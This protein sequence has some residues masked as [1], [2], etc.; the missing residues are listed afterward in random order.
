MTQP[1]EPGVWIFDGEGGRFPAAVFTTVE[2]AEEWIARHRL[3]GVLTWYPL[4]VPVYEW[5]IAKGYWKPSKDYQAEPRFIQQFSSAYTGHE[6][7][8]NGLRAGV[9]A[10]DTAD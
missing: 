7:Y 4:D 5:V 3:S 2:K 9:S 6:H 10:K 8:E 1:A